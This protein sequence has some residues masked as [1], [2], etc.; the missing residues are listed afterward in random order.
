MGR[1]QPVHHKTIAKVSTIGATTTAANNKNGQMTNRG[2]QMRKSLDSFSTS[3]RST[4]GGQITM[5]ASR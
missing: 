4:D 1:P 2:S 3:I 5:K